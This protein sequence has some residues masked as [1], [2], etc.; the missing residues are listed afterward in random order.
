M[1][2]LYTIAI[3]ALVALTAFNV[4]FAAVLL[5]IVLCYYALVS[6]ASMVR[7]GTGLSG[8]ELDKN[9]LWEAVLIGV[10]Y[11]VGVITLYF[12]FPVVALLLTPWI[13]HITAINT[14]SVLYSANIID[15]S[16]IDDEEDVDIHSEVDYDN[17]E[18]GPDNR[19]N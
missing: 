10:V 4:T 12:H 1:T 18:D 3:A 13:A 15:I 19:N 5:S 7:L 16:Y 9:I 6:F 17:V 8:A 11:A 14:I 2:Q